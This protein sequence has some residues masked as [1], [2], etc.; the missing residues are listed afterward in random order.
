MGGVESERS[1]RE[2]ERER[3]REKY[4]SN[5]PKPTCEMCKAN[6]PTD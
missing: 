5:I 6:M 2:R 3:E 4:I 1:K